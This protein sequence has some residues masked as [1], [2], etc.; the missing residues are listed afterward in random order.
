MSIEDRRS[1]RSLRSRDSLAD[2]SG[3]DN[4]AQH[5]ACVRRVKQARA[6]GRP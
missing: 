2:L 3:E 5:D 4:Q 6:A 1:L